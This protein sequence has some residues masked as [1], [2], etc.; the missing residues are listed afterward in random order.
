MLVTRSPKRRTVPGRSNGLLAVGPPSRVAL[1]QATGE[2]PVESNLRAVPI[3]C[4]SIMALR[5][6]E[7]FNVR[8]WTVGY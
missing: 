7:M 1:V 2:V 5:D 4:E 8:P 6:V 3:A